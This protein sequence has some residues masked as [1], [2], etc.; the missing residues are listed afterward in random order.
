MREISIIMGSDSDLAIMSNAA[1][2]LDFFNIEY[3]INIISA[4]RTPQKL[5]DFAINA[6]D[7]GIK[8]I[9][10]GAGGS[11]HLAGMVASLTNIPVIGVPIKTASLSGI[12]SLYSIVQ[13]PSGVPVATVAINGSINS[14]LLALQIL[15]INDND[16]Y[17]KLQ[18]YKINS[19]K[20]VNDKDEILS[21][22]K[23]QKYLDIEIS[24]K[25]L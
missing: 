8:V 15:A 22:I 23:Y 1:K 19:A 24:K 7:N 20:M 12:D 9:I 13:M 25:K 3:D 16:L 5:Y 21:S 18:N 4:H 17:Q 14:A 2:T 10:A 11:A 6:K